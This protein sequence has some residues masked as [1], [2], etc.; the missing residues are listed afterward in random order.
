M[1]CGFIG[2][3]VLFVFVGLG[4]VVKAL[5]VLEGRGGSAPLELFLRLWGP[6]AYAVLNRAVD[7]DLVYRRGD[8][9]RLAR[10]G[11]EL[12]KLLGEGCPVEARVARG[13]LWLKTP[14][15][16]HAVEPTPSYLLSIAYKL[17]EVCGEEPWRI[18][19]EIRR[20]LARATSRSLD[21]WLL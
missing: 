17:A 8:V 12:L 15:G 18:Y 19:A 7:W 10:R 11:R 6:Y 2:E 14:V 16:L 4:D 3:S 9:Y 13:R 5:R 1:Y 21:K 20:T